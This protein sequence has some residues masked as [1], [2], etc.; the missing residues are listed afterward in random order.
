MVMLDQHSHSI[1]NRASCHTG[2]S[3]GVVVVDNTRKVTVID[4]KIPSISIHD[5]KLRMGDISTML[6]CVTGQ[7]VGERGN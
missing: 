1:H 6:V 2:R 4:S 3:I 5:L 7:V